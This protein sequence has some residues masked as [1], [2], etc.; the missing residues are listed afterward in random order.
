MKALLHML[1]GPDNQSVDIA[2]VLWA[3]GFIN[4]LALSDIHAIRDHLY[5][6]VT[7]AYA[8]GAALTAGALGVAIKSKTEP[9]P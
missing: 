1:S 8:L 6:P 3:L 2:R 9:Q 4:F 7:Y 5:D